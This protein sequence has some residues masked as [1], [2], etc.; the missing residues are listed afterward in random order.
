MFFWV[1]VR[2]DVAKLA[3]FGARLAD[4]SLNRSAIRGD[5]YCLADDPAVGFSIWEA[6]DPTEFESL[7]AAWKL[8]YLESD[9]KPV[10]GPAEAMIHLAR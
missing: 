5:T 2:V 3:E 4:G 8:F 9:V 1:K 7:F 10:I 6:H